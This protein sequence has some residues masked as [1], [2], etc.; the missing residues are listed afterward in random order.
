MV[1]Q[2]MPKNNNSKITEYQQ[3]KNRKA[4]SEIKTNGIH[5]KR[6]QEIRKFVDFD[7]DLSKELSPYDKRKI[8][9]YSDEVKALTARP[10]QIV[11]PRS[12]KRLRQVQKFAQHEN[13]LKGLKVA[14]VP[15]NGKDKVKVKYQKNGKVIF[16]TEF[17]DSVYVELNP[18]KLTEDSITYVNTQIKKQAPKAKKFTI[19][20]AEYEIAGSHSVATIADEVSKLMTKYSVGGSGYKG[21]NDAQKWLGGVIG[22]TFK[23]QAE[24]REYD[25]AKNAAKKE[26]KRLRY[27]KRKKE[28]AAKERAKIK[29]AIAK[30]K[31]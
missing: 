1:A 30:N 26:G 18:K 8:K 27:N 31:K 13:K 9:T 3:R 10:N 6:F 2:I 4:A 24:Y 28:Q 22:H 14:F 12:Q 5:A 17:I 21:Y 11:K 20:T 29:K 25:K 16:S 23:N 15:T 19:A 7:F